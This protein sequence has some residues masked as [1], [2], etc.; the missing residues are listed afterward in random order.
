MAGP[1]ATDWLTAIGTVGTLGATVILFWWDRGQRLRG[2]RRAQASLI[3]GWTDRV[4]ANDAE[5]PLHIR[6]MSNE[7]VYNVNVFLEDED[8]QDADQ[9]IVQRS[10]SPETI[11]VHF[12]SVFP[13]QH[14][15]S[16]Q[17]SRNNPASS[18]ARNAPRV[19]LL[20]HDKDGVRWLRNWD[21]ALVVRKKD[22]PDAHR[23]FKSQDLEPPQSKIERRSAEPS[24][25]ELNAPPCRPPGAW[26]LAR[27][28]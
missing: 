17:V 10:I 21:G 6:N 11:N 12:I 20:F 7:P 13:A 2:E 18:G 26:V 3:S 27:I 16:W 23:R 5:R 22:N 4:K 24:T 8:D 28:L 19:A 15:F 25:H 9:D 1:N 14:T